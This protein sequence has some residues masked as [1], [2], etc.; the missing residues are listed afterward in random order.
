[1]RNFTRLIIVSTLI[2]TAPATLRADA[3]AD[4]EQG[5]MEYR[6][7]NLIEAMQLLEKSAA[8]GY[9]PAQTTLAFILDLAERDTQ[10]VYWY[11]QAADRNDAAG[12]FGLGGMYAKGE[13]LAKDPV[14][15]GR[16]IRQ[17]AQLNHAEA[18]RFY[19]RAL[20]SGQLGFD[21]AP[22]SAAEWYQKAAELGDQPSMN[23]L[24]QA[25]TQGQLGLPVDAGKAEAWNEKL[26][27]SD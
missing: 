14:K 23:R 5:I 8:E 6:K 11:Q 9:A 21:P 7:G 4:G 20:E 19:A 18:M 25:Y 2:L 22:S 26:N 1:M 24:K 17:A 15:A 27:Q 10:A 16:L 12:L 13:G 3:R